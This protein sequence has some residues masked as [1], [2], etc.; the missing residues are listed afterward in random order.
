MEQTGFPP[1]GGETG[2]VRSPDPERA[3]ITIIESSYQPVVKTFRWQNG[4][5]EK[6]HGAQI[7]KGRAMTVEADTAADL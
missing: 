6:Q 1:H 2:E 7:S 3:H 4:A 5:V